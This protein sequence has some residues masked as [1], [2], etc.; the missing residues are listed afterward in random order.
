MAVASDLPSASAPARDAARRAV[1]ER[2]HATGVVEQ[3]ARTVLGRIPPALG[4]RGRALLGRHFSALPWAVDDDVQLASI[5]GPGAG[6]RTL[7]LAADLV[8]GFGWRTGS[9]RVEAELRALPLAS[10]A[11]AP[12]PA[13][14]PATIATD[15]VADA[16][17]RRTYRTSAAQG[18]DGR[19]GELEVVDLASTFDGPIV[20]EAQAHPRL[21][22]LLTGPGTGG[23]VPGWIRPGG[24]IDPTLARLFATF[25]EVTGV[26]LRPG[27]YTIEV[28]HP[29]AWETVLAP[30]LMF[31]TGHLTPA[32]RVD[33][34]RSASRAHFELAGLDPL[35]PRG[36]AK[37]R[38]ALSSPDP[39]VRAEAMRLVAPDRFTAERA[40]RAALDDGARDVRRAAVRAASAAPRQYLRPLLER[41]C[42]DRDA[43]TRY[44]AVEGLRRLGVGS[45]RPVIERLARDGDAQVAVA[46][47]AA[48]RS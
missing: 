9:F 47:A 42:A 15:P 32:R 8:V 35:T 41:F 34:A 43:C 18:A 7:E 46:V 29:D 3:I 25:L 33:A 26:L 28:E 22:R 4:E 13:P 39:D 23:N 10:V 48:L 11:P 2:G 30:L 16:L 20:A 1:L 38:D 12:A 27:S 5:V 44:H 19:T 45:S 24:T 14:A 40:W 17:L 36:I 21:V 37:L 6:W 31:A